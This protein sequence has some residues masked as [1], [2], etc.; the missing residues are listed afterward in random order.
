[1]SDDAGPFEEDAPAGRPGGGRRRGRPLAVAALTLVGLVAAVVLWLAL[2]A[3]DTMEELRRA[4]AEA[5]VSPAVVVALPPVRPEPDRAG[6]PAGQG[7]TARAEAG[8]G[9]APAET[10]GPEPAGTAPPGAPRIAVIVPDLAMSDARTRA[11]IDR[12]PAA[13]TLAFSPYGRDL[14]SWLAAAGADGHESLMMVPMEP[15]DYPRLDPGPH[16]LRIGL[17]P[18][19]NLDRLGWVLARGTGHGGVLTEMGSR[20]TASPEAL[21]PVMQAV[22]ARDLMFVAGSEAD[23][24]VA[25]RLADEFSVPHAAV[26]LALD[27]DLTPNAIDLRLFELESLA[28]ERGTAVGIASPY[29]LV[30]DRLAAWLSTLPGKGL[31]LVPVSA[32]AA[33]RT[34]VAADGAAGSDGAGALP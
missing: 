18:E 29:P 24:A 14:D 30:L 12:M 15:V 8:A 21:R 11:A 7:G 23:A 31:A 32:V 27:A 33:V 9:A 4:G 20:F 16:T 6:Q 10:P 1:M 28:R 34:D 22:A 3:A 13:V 5:A 2:T 19:S 26:D 25:A 17:P